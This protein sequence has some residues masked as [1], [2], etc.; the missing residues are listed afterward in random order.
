VPSPPVYKANV[1]L[2]PNA[3]LMIYG[4]GT[5]PGGEEETCVHSRGYLTTPLCDQ[6][7]RPEPR[8]FTANK[9]SQRTRGDNMSMK[10]WSAISYA[11][12]QFQSSSG[13]M[14]SCLR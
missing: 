13:L 4:S 9:I 14:G 2:W 12:V 6:Q 11:S 3:Y 1:F 10:W 7:A 8:T 5:A